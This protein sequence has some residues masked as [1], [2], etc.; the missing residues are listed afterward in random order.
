VRSPHAD[1]P[2]RLADPK[3]RSS[4]AT[5]LYQ[6]VLHLRTLTFRISPPQGRIPLDLDSYRGIVLVG[7]GIGVTPLLSVLSS[8]AIAARTRSK[9]AP[10]PRVHLV[11]TIRQPQML[12]LFSEDIAAAQQAGVQLSLALYCTD[13]SFAP[14]QKQL[15]VN[16]VHL[17]HDEEEGKAGGSGGGDKS[18]GIGLSLRKGRAKI[19]VELDEFAS[20]SG[21]A[22]LEATEV[23]V[24]I[25]GPAQMMIDAQRAAMERKFH[26]HTETFE[27]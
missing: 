10:L 22:K 23:A 14:G 7:G 13:R 6:D 11:W 15:T 12:E 2:A 18:S 5:A 19:D 1:A 25:C 24:L 4:F 16:P 8:L 9:A 20:G 21:G 3:A 26:V 27:L 17:Q